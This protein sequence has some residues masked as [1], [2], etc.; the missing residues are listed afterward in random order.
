MLERERIWVREGKFRENLWEK[1]L[2]FISRELNFFALVVSAFY[3]VEI[4]QR[5]QTCWVENCYRYA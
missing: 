1:G 4:R 5:R 3:K 2:D